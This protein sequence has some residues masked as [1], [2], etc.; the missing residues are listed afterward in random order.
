M[1][2][3]YPANGA[4]Y[5][6]L[7]DQVPYHPGHSNPTLAMEGCGT[8][9]SGG[10][11]TGFVTQFAEDDA[12]PFVSIDC[13]EVIGAYDP[14]D[15][16]GYPK[17]YGDEHFIDLGQDLEYRIRFQ[18]T[19]SDTAFN[20][21]I[22]DVLSPHLDISTLQPGASSHPYELSIRGRDT[23]LFFFD[24][25]MLPDSNVNEPASHGF[26]KFR[27][28]QSLTNELGDVIENE[29]GI[30]FDFNDPVITNKTIHRL[31]DHYIISSTSEPQRLDIQHTMQPNPATGETTLTLSGQVP[32][33][34]MKVHLFDVAGHHIQV[35]ELFA[36][37]GKVDLSALN[38]GLYFYEITINDSKVGM[39]KVVVN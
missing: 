5:V 35:Q 15:K 18:N 33:G 39:G 27:I 4:T 30:Y 36:P 13:Q 34:K 3:A 17:G 16:Y 9:P 2:Y 21:V 28:K 24:D 14:N 26:V 32:N 11:S 1:E 37:I 10:F 12:D 23:L 29:A 8:D 7:L 38:T 19:G 20:V 6:M 25:I 22:E 31:G